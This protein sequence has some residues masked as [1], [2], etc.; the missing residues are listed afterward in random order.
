[1]LHGFI[2]IICIMYRNIFLL[3]NHEIVG[4]KRW[5]ISIIKKSQKKKKKKFIIFLIIYLNFKFNLL[6]CIVYFNWF[7]IFKLIFFL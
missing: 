2:V 4:N 5:I 1:M 7:L 3:T 6:N